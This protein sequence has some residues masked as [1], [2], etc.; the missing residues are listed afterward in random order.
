MIWKSMA[1][2][3]RRCG[4]VDKTVIGLLPPTPKGEF[5]ITFVSYFGFVQNEKCLAYHS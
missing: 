1:T 4:T 5:G 2:T 3:A